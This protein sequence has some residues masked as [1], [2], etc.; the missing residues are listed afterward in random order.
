VLGA[1]PGSEWTISRIQVEAG[2]Q[3]VIVTDGIVEAQGPEERF[4]EGRLREQLSGGSNPALATQR[5]E[6]A[7]SSFTGGA[8][9]DDI[10]ILAIER[11]SSEPLSPPADLALDGWMMGL[12]ERLYES[13][14]RRDVTGI[15][16]I[17]DEKMDF[18][19]SGTAEAIGRDTPYVGPA[20][21]Q[22]YMADVAKVWEELL[23]TPSELERKG[24]RLLV[25]GR[26]YARSRKL[27]I[28]DVPV[29]WIWEVRD[30]RFIRGEVFSDPEQ[31]VAR[32]AAVESQTSL[33]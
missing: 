3:L 32:F 33:S 21:L 18:F 23:I 28:R 8:L 16:G 1:F 27:G 30:R 19:P 5:L 9:D 24:E 14:N 26:V 20:G 10:A 6:G 7:L 22:E 29:A 11:G 2:R 12:V 25:R 31:A 15:V 4:G 17:C 13:F